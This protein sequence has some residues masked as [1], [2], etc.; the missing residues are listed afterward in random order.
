MRAVANLLELPALKSSFLACDNDAILLASPSD[1]RVVDGKDLWAEWHVALAFEE[2][3]M[4]PFG[5]YPEDPRWTPV[6][7]N[8]ARLCL[9]LQRFLSTVSLILSAW[10]PYV[11]C[12]TA[13]Q[14][15]PSPF[16]PGQIKH[17]LL[18]DD[19][20]D[21]GSAKD[22]RASDTHRFITRKPWQ[23]VA[24]GL[25]LYCWRLL[26]GG[27]INNSRLAVVMQDVGVHF[28]GSYASRGILEAALLGVHCDVGGGAKLY[29]IHNEQ[30]KFGPTHEWSSA[31]LL[32]NI[33]PDWYFALYF[34]LIRYSWV[35]KTEGFWVVQL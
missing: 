28:A 21:G 25:Q 33:P 7:L 34:D 3:Q 22:P 12:C 15:C 20:R 1:S 16:D 10:H 4:R 23:P 27:I 5:K 31:A 32:M 2:K 11:S 30:Q 6:G 35:E 8:Y 29:I 18:F 26:A 19:S 13:G 14:F 9:V 17:Q 24:A